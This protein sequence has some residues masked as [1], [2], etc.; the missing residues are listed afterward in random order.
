[1]LRM[2]AAAG[3]P[4]DVF[5]LISHTGRTRVLFEVAELAKESGATVLSLTKE[6]SPL[7]TVSDCSITLNIA[8]NTEE[9]LPMTSRI[10]QLVILDV[11]A[12]GTMLERGAELQPHLARLKESLKVTRF[13]EE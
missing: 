13:P 6:D 8:E 9:Y 12:T 3:E 10:V 2:L 5:F 11:L 7:A 1:M 4:G